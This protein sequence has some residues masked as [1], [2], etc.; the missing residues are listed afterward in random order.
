[1]S[2]PS[3]WHLTLGEAADPSVIPGAFS[4]DTNAWMLYSS[5]VTSEGITFTS[6]DGRR[7][8]T[9]TLLEDGIEIIYQR[10]GPVSTRIPLAVDPQAFF[11]DPTEYR[12][13]PGLGTWTW[14]LVNGIQVEVR[15]ESTLSAQ[16]YTESFPYLSQTEDPNRAYPGGHYLPFP[17]SVVSLRDSGNF[18]VQIIAK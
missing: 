4:D 7:L 1:L 10:S 3:E 11:F 9:Y 13:T 5:D 18:K 15:T 6:P 17:L 14:G 2:D 16:S 8:K 12:S